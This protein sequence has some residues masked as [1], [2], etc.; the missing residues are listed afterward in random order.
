MDRQSWTC[1]NPV[2]GRV[3]VLGKLPMS[4]TIGGRVLLKTCR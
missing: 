1:G 3:W 4:G 2:V